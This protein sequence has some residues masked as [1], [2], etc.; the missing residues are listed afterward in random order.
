MVRYFG[1]GR[2]GDVDKRTELDIDWRASVD[3]GCAEA[4]EVPGIESADS[5]LAIWQ[6]VASAKWSPHRPLF[7][8]DVSSHKRITVQLFLG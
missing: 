5:P 1:V 3:E 6:N 7:V 2:H 4:C 8:A